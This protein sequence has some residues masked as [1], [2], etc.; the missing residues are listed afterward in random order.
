MSLKQE[1]SL[2]AF[3]DLDRKWVRSSLRAVL[4]WGQGY[5]REHQLTTSPGLPRLE[6]SGWG[7]IASCTRLAF[8]TPSYA[9]DKA[10]LGVQLG[11]NTGLPFGVPLPLLMLVGDTCRWCALCAHLRMGGLSCLNGTRFRMGMEKVGKGF[12]GENPCNS[13]EMLEKGHAWHAGSKPAFSTSGPVPVALSG[14][15]LQVQDSAPSRDGSLPAGREQVT[16]AS[17]SPPPSSSFRFLM[18]ENEALT[19]LFRIRVLASDLHHEWS[20]VRLFSKALLR[21]FH[22]SGPCRSQAAW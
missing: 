15:N 13:W 12:R 2:A 7:V 17:H 22:D 8:F 4:G 6:R 14:W 20:A 19:Q 11:W 3:F 18:G 1:N 9:V 10:I 5:R 16:P 21:Q